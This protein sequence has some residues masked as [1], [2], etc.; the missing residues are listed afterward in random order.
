MHNLT[1]FTLTTSLAVLLSACSNKQ[2]SAIPI[3]KPQQKLA[4]VQW[5]VSLWSKRRAF[6]EHVEK[7]AELVSK[8]TDGDFKIN[9]SYGGLSKN[10]Q[11][12]SAI[13]SSTVEMAQFCSFYHKNRNPTITVTELPF[14]KNLSLERIAKIYTEVFKH[15][16]VT[17][18]LARW[19]ATLLMPTPLPQYNIIA[20]GDPLEKLEDFN[21]LGVRAPNSVMRVLD[22]LGAIKALVPFGEVHNSMKLGVIDAAVFAPHAHL[23]TKTTQIGVW[24]TT[25]LNLYSPNC[26]VIVSTKALN[27]LNDSHRVALLGSIDEALT[28][29]VNNYN[30]NVTGKFEKKAKATGIK[31]LTFSPKQTARLNELA[32]SVRKDWVEK[33]ANDF[34][35]KELL[36]FTENLFN[37][38]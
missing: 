5:D 29:Y 18:D 8:K 32:A 14:S 7:L 6:T 16:T 15:P 36:E 11:N 24:G 13:A 21:G 38:E 22:K 28:H 20:T 35:S 34:D 4:S 23:A 10:T 3:E 9:I 30:N 1:K 37:T 27:K 12:L 19:N 17:K 33:Y 25:N 26:P 31:M 2:N